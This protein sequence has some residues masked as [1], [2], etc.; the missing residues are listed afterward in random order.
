MA[1]RWDETLGAVNLYVEKLKDAK[2]LLATFDA[3]QGMEFDV[4]R[5][6]IPSDEWEKVTSKDATPRG[7]TPLYDAVGRVISIADKSNADKTIIVIMT[8][9]CE[10]AST[11]YTGKSAKEAIARCKGKGWEVVFLGADFDATLQA[12]DVGVNYGKT[13]SMTRGHYGVACMDFA[14][15]SVAYATMDSCPIEFDDKTRAKA[16]GK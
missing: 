7:T 3:S 1:S 16:Q 9:G 4:L 10:N 13:L 6:L 12:A 11:E 15:Q 5:D 2:V 8:D 14:A